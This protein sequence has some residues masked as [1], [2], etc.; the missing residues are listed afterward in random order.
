MSK[1]GNAGLVLSW[2]NEVAPFLSNSGRTTTGLF[3]MS[4][5]IG[6]SNTSAVL[7]MLT[8]RSELA[9]SAFASLRPNC[10]TISAPFELVERLG[11]EST[12]WPI[13]RA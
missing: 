12:A 3:C 2:M 9:L 6:W 5:I 4:Q 1:S 11:P 13:I 7:A 8:A 10:I